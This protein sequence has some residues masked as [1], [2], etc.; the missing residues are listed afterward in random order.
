MGK[1]REIS[2]FFKQHES[3]LSEIPSRAAWKKLERRL[4][5][6]QKRNRLGFL[7]TF[8]MVAAVLLLV[9]FTFMMTT[10]SVKNQHLMASDVQAIA[11]AEPIST[12]EIDPEVYK[13]VEFTIKFKDRM[14]NPIEEG[15]ESQELIVN[16]DYTSSNSSFLME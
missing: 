2:D 12:Q 7:K 10:L 6:H 15:E 14:T 16:D 8:A 13:E 3:E 4:D 9:V 11:Q 1:Q 5:A